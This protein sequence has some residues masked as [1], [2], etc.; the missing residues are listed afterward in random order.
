MLTPERHPELPC[1][2]EGTYDRP[3]RMRTLSVVLGTLLT[4]AACGEDDGSSTHEGDP[5]SGI[6]PAPKPGMTAPGA[7]LAL[8]ETATVPVRTFQDPVGGTAEITVLAIDA[9]P[10]DEV[11]PSGYSGGD[12]AVI[13]LIRAEAKL[14]K[15]TDLRVFEPATDLVATT[16]NGEIA[17]ALSPEDAELFGCEAGSDGSP[18]KGTALEVCEAVESPNGAEVDQVQFA[19]YAGDYSV[20]EGAPLTWR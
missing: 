12:G 4:L 19:P 16:S 9:V 5:G 7:E 8:G 6:T 10:E 14:T 17:Q 1:D 15:V 20:R 13:Y 11:A 2:V 18:E 3:M